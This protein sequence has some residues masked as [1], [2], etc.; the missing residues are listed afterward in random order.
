NVPLRVAYNEG[1]RRWFAMFIEDSESHISRRQTIEEDVHIVAEAYVL[2]TLPDVEADLSFAFARVAAV[3]LYDAVFKLQP[4]K[5]W[6]ERRLIE[7]HHVKPPVPHVALCDGLF[8]SRV[9]AGTLSGA[10]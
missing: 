8:R 4:G 9:H 1:C 2:G 10:E 7:H 5:L 3:E 6:P